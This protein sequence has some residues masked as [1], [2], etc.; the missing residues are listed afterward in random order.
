MD[1]RWDFQR[2]DYLVE[3]TAALKAVPMAETKADLMVGSKVV[4][5]AKMSKWQ[6][7]Y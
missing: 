4:R 7:R 2:V 6:R 5:K 3:R 1:W